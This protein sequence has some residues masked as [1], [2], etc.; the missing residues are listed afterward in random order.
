MSRVLPDRPNIAGFTLV[1]ALVATLLMA[2]V[3]STLATATAQWLPNWNRGF[4]RVQQTQVLAVGVERLVADFA[5]AQ[6]VSQGRHTNRPL[7]EGTEESVTFI[8]SALG[9]N[10]SYGLD[11]VRIAE[12]A[13]R[14]GGALV[15]SRTA[16]APGTAT[17]ERFGDPIV[18]FRSPYRVSFAYADKTG[19]WRA[20]WHDEA[21]LPSAVRLTVRDV[22]TDRVLPI[23]TVAVVRANLPAACAKGGDDCDELIEGER[24][25]ARNASR[26]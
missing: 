8:R 20:I 5:A 26:R 24:E 14:R 16:F 25:D 12:I 22:A 13:D 4:A 6:F 9:P 2:I 1:E 10:T 19:V 11:V 17:I 18:L 7:F 21:T 23:S 3:L 15:R